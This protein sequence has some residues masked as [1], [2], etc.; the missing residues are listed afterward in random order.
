LPAV[1]NDRAQDN[2]EPLLAIADTAGGH[3]PELARQTALKLVGTE[4]AHLSCNQELLADI[5]EIFYNLN[6]DKVFTVDLITALSE[7]EARSWATY[8]KYAPITA[9]QIADKLKGYKIQP[10]DVRAGPQVKKGYYLQDFTDA[11]HRYLSIDH[12][13]R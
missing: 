5:Q 11:F 6:A 13:C 4:E 9:K 12:V 1:L 8:N 7:N 2:W 3:W 10:R